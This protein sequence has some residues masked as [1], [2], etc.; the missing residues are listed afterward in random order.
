[1][2]GEFNLSA[3]KS[4]KF[5]VILLLYSIYG[6]IVTWYLEKV[7]FKCFKKAAGSGLQWE[8]SEGSCST[9]DQNN[10]NNPPLLKE[11]LLCKYLNIN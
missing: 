1:M 11:V 10:N 5:H 3:I 7:I 8:A 6:F 2:Y 4:L 9:D